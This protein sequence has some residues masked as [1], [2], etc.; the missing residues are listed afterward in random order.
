MTDIIDFYKHIPQNKQKL[1]KGFKNHHILP[2]SHIL[3]IGGTGSGKSTALLNFI[4]KK[5]GFYKI[6]IYAPVM[7][8]LY[9]L[10]LEKIPEI[11]IYNKIAEFPPLADMD[12]EDKTE[13]LIVFDDFITL[14]PKEQQKIKEYLVAGR[15]KNCS[16]FL[17]SQNYT[18]VPKTISR[19]INY[20][21]IFKINDNVSINHIIRN[22]NLDEIPKEVIKDAYKEC[23]AEPRN[24][25]TIDLKGEGFKRYRHNF[26]GFLNLAPK[27]YQ[28]DV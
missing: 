13:K 10:L 20:F 22:H 15:K 24:F 12:E 23:T 2:A 19:N 4:H 7:D 1:D 18:E 11:D 21:F 17:M 5:D 28:Y 25:F 26:T 14:K 3:C 9:E 6:M 8:P 27:K 16:C